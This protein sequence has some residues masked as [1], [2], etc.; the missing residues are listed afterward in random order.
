MSL[1]DKQ[2]KQQEYDSKFSQLVNMK[3]N[4]DGL[5]NNVAAAA[6][7]LEKERTLA[8]TVSAFSSLYSERSKIIKDEWYYADQD[9]KI[10]VLKTEHDINKDK[11]SSIKNASGEN[12]I[13][14]TIPTPTDGNIDDIEKTI[15]TEIDKFSA[16]VDT[17][18]L[19]YREAL[20]TEA[21]NG[22]KE[23]SDLLKE[24]NTKLK[25]KK[26]GQTDDDI[27][28]SVVSTIGSG[29]GVAIIG[30]RNF[31]S[32]I[33]EDREKLQ[34]LLEGKKKAMEEGMASHVDATL[35]NKETFKAFYDNPNTKMLWY[36]NGKLSSASVRDVLIS[37]GMTHV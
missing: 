5:L 31:V 35:N 11:E 17:N 7:F 30:N 18:L 10:K 24:Y 3:S 27:F 12:S 14:T 37:K 9:L 21:A 20:K 2:E 16:K 36:N 15:D 29:S 28:Q 26:A 6:T 13:I 22:N 23:A 19:S 32:E 33:K 1:E 34:I 25:T 8:D 4:R